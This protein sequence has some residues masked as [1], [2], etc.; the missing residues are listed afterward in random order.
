VGFVRGRG[1]GFVVGAGRRLR[2]GY[3][4]LGFLFRLG[5]DVIASLGMLIVCSLGLV[6]VVLLWA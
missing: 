6:L 1:F 5:W 2:L 4:C 3:R